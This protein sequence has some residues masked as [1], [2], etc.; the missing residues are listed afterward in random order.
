MALKYPKN[1]HFNKLQMR[2]PDYMT[3]H[4]TYIY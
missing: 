3:W 4:Y 2:S 1:P